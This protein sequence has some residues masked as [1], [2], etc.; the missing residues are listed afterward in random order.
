MGSHWKDF[1][2]NPRRLC[3]QLHEFFLSKGAVVGTTGSKME[4]PLDAKIPVSRDWIVTLE[5]PIIEDFG[6]KLLDSSFEESELRKGMRR[7]KI[8]Y[9][10]ADLDIVSTYPILGM[11]FNIAR[12]TAMFETCKIEGLD[13]HTYREFGVNL[14]AGV[15]NS[16]VIAEKSLV[17]KV[18]MMFLKTLNK[19]MVLHRLEKPV[20]N[21]SQI[22]LKQNV[23]LVEQ[24]A[25]QVRKPM[26]QPN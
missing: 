21:A 3:D 15:A 25:W 18:S 8:F 12:E 11:L 7:S 22:V 9:H 5:A 20:I 26:R 1:N 24:E 14:T 17:L 2:S 23:R 19:H 13:Y 10:N 6:L 4:T 16:M